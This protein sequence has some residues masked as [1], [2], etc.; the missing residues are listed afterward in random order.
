MR[1][2]QLAV[3]C[4]AV[5]VASAGQVQAGIISTSEYS[6]SG[7]DGEWRFG[8]TGWNQSTIID[9]VADFSTVAGLMSDGYVDDF[10]GSAGATNGIYTMSFL[11]QLTFEF[12]V[13]T[14]FLLDDLSLISSRAYSGAT[15]ITL[16][17]QLDGGAWQTATTST[18][19]SLGMFPT[20][21]PN[22][23]P[24]TQYSLGFGSVL[25]DSF[26]LTFNGGSQVSIHEVSVSGSS[27]SAVPEPSSLALFGIG[28]CVA[29]LG[30]GRR[31]RRGKQ[32]EATA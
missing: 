27:V 3:V 21:S 4:V 15:D 22:Y 6:L 2:I 19:T 20:L 32:Q 10:G 5:L 29:G 8:S 30:G 14:D 12:N 26:R 7:L 23:S 17:Y 13:G 18:T 25:A 31:R 11:N 28:A 1:A 9:N 16:E 24:G